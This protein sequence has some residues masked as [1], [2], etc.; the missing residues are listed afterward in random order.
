VNLYFLV[1]GKRSEPKI[2]PKWFSYLLPD[3]TRVETLQRLNTNT[4]YLFSGMGYPSLLNH[5]QHAIFDA[6][7]YKVDYLIITVDCDDEKIEDRYSDINKI[8]EQNLQGF[9]KDRIVILLQNKCIE[10]WLLGNRN[11]FTYNPQDSELIDY[12][13]HY[14]V[15]TNDPELMPEYS[16]FDSISQFH[17]DY[18]KR[19]LRE[20]HIFYS[21]SNPSDT[22]EV[23]YLKELLKRIE[24]TSGDLNTF[25]QFIKTLDGFKCDET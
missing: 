17:T 9:D 5:I 25:R 23:Y 1:E 10:T 6:K 15:K 16:G 14:N 20:K 18:L 7:K 22:S 2:Y 11:I 21:K 8:V 13:R 12:I 3:Y 24:Q 19:L 4:Y